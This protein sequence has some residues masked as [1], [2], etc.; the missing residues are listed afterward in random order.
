VSDVV[1][2][3]GRPDGMRSVPL[4]G[5]HD[6]DHYPEFQ[7]FLREEFHLQA[8][9]FAAPPVLAV[10]AGLF[11][12]VF[13]G[14]SGE[15]F[16]SGVEVN[17]LVPGLEPMDDTATGKGLW[18]VLRWLVREVGGDWTA[19]GLVAVARIYRLPGG[20]EPSA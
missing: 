17:A 14:R 10:E 2:R 3:V 9:P 15:H 19:D 12:L 6:L 18:A 1:R 4:L 8:D 20:V 7:R 13:I 5:E 16:P 11:E